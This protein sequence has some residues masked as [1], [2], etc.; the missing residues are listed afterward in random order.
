MGNLSEHFSSKDFIC[1]C[2]DCRG[3]EYRIHLGLVGALE[4]IYEN[5]KKP[6]KIVKGYWCDD[7]NEKNNSGKKSTHNQGKAVHIAIEGVPPAEII[8]FA[9]TLPELR[10]IGYYPED[11]SVHLDTRRDDRVE[12]IKERGSYHAFTTEKRHALGL[13]PLQAPVPTPAPAPTPTPNETSGA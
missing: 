6:I 4:A 13:P 10:G 5:F 7:Y 3:R 1:N 11:G 2:P 12:W 8:K 9:E